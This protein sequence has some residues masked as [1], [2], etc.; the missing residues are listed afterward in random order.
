MKKV[1][2]ICIQNSARSQMAEAF[3]NKYTDE[4]F[5]AFSGG[6]EVGEVNPLVIEAMEEKDIDISYNKAKSAFDFVK[7]GVLFSYVV[8]VCDESV[9]QKCP[10]FPGV[11]ERIMMSFVDPST[12]TGNKKE[13]LEKIRKVRDKI[14]KEVLDFIEYIKSGNKKENFKKKWKLG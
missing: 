9:S 8:T 1:L 12:F 2:F 11:R 14:E 13:K 4:N 3:F 6:L 5:K 7:E 10:I